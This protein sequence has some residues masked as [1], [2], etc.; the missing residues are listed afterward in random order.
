MY[1]TLT[2][3]DPMNRAQHLAWCK[4]R[5]LEYVE[6]GNIQEAIASMLSDLSKHPET[7]K[8]ADLGFMLSLSVRT[9]RDARKFVEGFN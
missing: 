1:E 8:S 3:E 9:E 2:P 4:T 5:A 6:A 7:Q